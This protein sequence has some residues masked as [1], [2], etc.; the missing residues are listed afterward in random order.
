MDEVQLGRYVYEVCEQ[1][2]PLIEDALGEWFQTLTEGGA[3]NGE[4]LN[5]GSFVSLKAYTLLQ[6]FIGDLMPW[7]EFRGYASEQAMKNGERDR[8]LAARAPSGPQVRRALDAGFRVNGID[9]WND[10]KKLVD[11][12][13]AQTVLGEGVLR[14]METLG[15]GSPKPSA[16]TTAGTDSKTSTD[17]PS[18]A[19]DGS[20]ESTIEGSGSPSSPAGPEAFEDSRSLASTAS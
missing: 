15:Q 17:Q 13:V 16:P 5:L 3:P 20:G 9:I 2:L 18:P 8:T 7:Y 14:L 4:N 12:T 6:A 19:S 10:V 11:P 1:A